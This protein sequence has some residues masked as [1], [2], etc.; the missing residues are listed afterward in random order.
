VGRA[1][2]R[3]GV[4]IWLLPEFR[5]CPRN[6]TT[7][8][9]AVPV[10]VCFSQLLVL[11]AFL[12]VHPHPLICNGSH[13]RRIRSVQIVTAKVSCSSGICPIR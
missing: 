6:D 4:A 7:L 13:S 11:L 5:R 12:S 8:T 9:R 2:L 1:L 3:V 10:S